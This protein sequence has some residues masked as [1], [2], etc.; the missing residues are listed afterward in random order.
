MKTVRHKN[1][2][3]YQTIIKR[4]VTVI[5]PATITLIAGLGM[6]FDKDTSILTGVIGL[7]TA[8]IGTILGI[9]TKKYNQKRRK[10]YD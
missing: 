4:W 6:L 8:F 2:K 5:A 10:F 9:T 7:F 3:S 1:K